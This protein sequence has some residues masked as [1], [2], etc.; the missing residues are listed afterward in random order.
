VASTVNDQS[1]KQGIALL[2][3]TQGFVKEVLFNS[4]RP[5]HKLIPQ[6][7]WTTL[8][9]QGNINKALNFL[10]Q[11]QEERHI[12]NW[13]LNV[14]LEEGIKTFHFAGTHL[15]DDILIVGSQSNQGL[16][17]LYE[18]M[19]RINNEQTNQIRSLAK[20][21]YAAYSQEQNPTHE[22]L[23]EIAQLNNEMVAIQRELAR[24]NA[25]LER[26][27]QQKNQFLGMAAHDL[28]NPLHAILSYSEYLLEE[29]S[30][31][32]APDHLEFL[33]SIRD[34]SF[35]MSDLVNDLLDVSKIEAG[36]LDLFLE[37]IEFD[38]FLENNLRLN[39]PLATKKQVDFQLELEQG[40][41]I[42]GDRT[43]LIQVL[44]NLFSNAIKHSP[45]KS[46]I[47]IQLQQEQ[48]HLV[49]SIADHGPGIPEDK[50]EKV[51][52]PFET[53]PSPDPEGKKSTGLGLVIVKR[54]VEGHEGQIWLES[55]VNQGTTFYVSLPLAG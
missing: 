30:S 35:Y 3:D 29:T 4:I 44:D 10:L 55:E 9:A 16:T 36:K 51:F 54:I 42:E 18:E 21:R 5:D 7:P 31:L 39:Q 1:Q 32:L 50:L 46:T 17:E 38:R 22:Y 28:R 26:L 11:V 41:V 15:E 6:Q 13:E 25:Q 52:K 12:S 8:L 47:D 19:M 34:Y 40:L 27:N 24:K 45:E 23:N 53:L 37:P 48:D 33:E 20:D 14:T 2:C 49:L 43:K